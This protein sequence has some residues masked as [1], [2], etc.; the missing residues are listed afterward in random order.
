[1]SYPEIRPVD[2]ADCCL[3]CDDIRQ[4]VNEIHEI[5]TSLKA[6]VLEAQKNPMLAA[7]LPPVF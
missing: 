5:M 7:M 3:T 4:Q 2:K 6:F 1:M